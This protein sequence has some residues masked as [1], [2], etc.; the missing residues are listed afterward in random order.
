MYL[1]G[2]NPTSNGIAVT[3]TANRIGPSTLDDSVGSEDGP[4]Y[5]N[6]SIHQFVSPIQQSCTLSNTF[7][8]YLDVTSD[9]HW[10]DG[11]VS[12]NK[13]IHSRIYFPARASISSNLFF[14]IISCF[15]AAFLF[16][17]K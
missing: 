2:R 10:A 11:G 5:V 13:L 4:A 14:S 16:P 9:G 15:S 8:G 7:P 17:C 3:S 12:L 1:V 6:S